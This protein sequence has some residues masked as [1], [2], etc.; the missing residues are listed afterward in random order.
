MKKD[1]E[2]GGKV[3][4]HSLSVKIWI[5]YWKY[6]LKGTHVITLF[7]YKEQSNLKITVKSWKNVIET[8]SNRNIMRFWKFI[9]LPMSEDLP[10]K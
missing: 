1:T 5:N 3:Q 2:K 7:E 6:S 10:W 8:K 4:E 9:I